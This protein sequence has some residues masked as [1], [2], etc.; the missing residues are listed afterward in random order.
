MY[1]QDNR[2][3]DLTTYPEIYRELV[4]QRNATIDWL[5]ENALLVRD[6]RVT[7]QNEQEWQRQGN[8]RTYRPIFRE[9]V[10]DLFERLYSHDATEAIYDFRSIDLK[11]WSDTET[12]W[13]ERELQA[14]QAIIGKLEVRYNLQ[15]KMIFRYD[16]GQ[17]VLLLNGIEVLSC[18]QKTLR[19]RLLT[20][21][22]SE[23]KKQWDNESIVDYFVES[24]HYEQD[25]LKDKA[26]EKAAS[27]IKKDVAA[28]TAV[29]DFLLV[30]NSAIKINPFY[31]GS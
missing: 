29:K 25:E 27:D 31:V 7:K 15:Y 5:N 4:Y 16:S 20:T 19:H 3:L 8:A 24:F 17:F 10:L 6:R 14:L 12:N 2:Y 28:K 11:D 26:I 13:L 9:N 18:G 22:Y 23:P 21:L 1:E 30:S